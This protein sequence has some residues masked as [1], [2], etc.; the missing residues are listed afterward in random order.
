MIGSGIDSD[1]GGHPDFSGLVNAGRLGGLFA[2]VGGIIGGIAGTDDVYELGTMSHA[3][4][5]LTVQ[6]ILIEGR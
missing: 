5:V 4:R 1:G 2:L 3:Q 6:E